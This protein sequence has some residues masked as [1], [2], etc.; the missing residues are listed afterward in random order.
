MSKIVF[1]ISDSG[2]FSEP[3]NG[4]ELLPT[5]FGTAQ[6]SRYGVVKIVGRKGGVSQYMGADRQQFNI[7][8]I[9]L[10][11]AESM[12]T[13]RQ[14]LENLLWSTDSEE[15]G[16]SVSMSVIYREGF[17][18]NPNH[19]KNPSFEDWNDETDL[20]WWVEASGDSASYTQSTDAVDG[21]WSIRFKSWDTLS[22][23]YA[24]SPLE[25]ITPCDTYIFTIAIK[26]SGE[27]KP[28]YK[29]CTKVY[30]END[31]TSTEEKFGEVGSD[32]DWV[33]KSYTKSYD[34]FYTKYRVKVDGGLYTGSGN[35]DE[36]FTASFDNLIIT[37]YTDGYTE[38]ENINIK[39]YNISQ[40]RG[41]KDI[42]DVS[43]DMEEE[44]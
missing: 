16:K 34:P 28:L 2:A 38:S 40:R 8:G 1:Q 21:T 27:A 24:I 22:W 23:A 5:S 11:D 20:Q 4:L 18:S 41:A 39:G 14:A 35:G 19:I 32:T 37:A 7:G 44:Y 25:N 10:G 29:A 33:I 42:Y 6:M 30:W 17:F 3:A 9:F 12:S 26:A 31:E 36:G 13:K 43:I 15:R